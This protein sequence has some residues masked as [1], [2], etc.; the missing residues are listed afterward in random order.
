VKIA[1]YIFV[2]LVAGM[3]GAIT[4]HFSIIP[5]GAREIGLPADVKTLA[6]QE[7]AKRVFPIFSKQLAGSVVDAR[8]TWLTTD[9]GLREN[10]E[11]VAFRL[12]AKGAGW[13]ELCQAD[14]FV[15]GLASPIKPPTDTVAQPDGKFEHHLSYRIIG[16]T[17][18]DK[19]WTDA[20]SGRLDQ[21]CATLGR[22]IEFFTLSDMVDLRTVTDMVPALKARSSANANGSPPVR[23]DGTVEFCRDP[24]QVLRT[25]PLDKFAGAYGLADCGIRESCLELSY[26]PDQPPPYTGHWALRAKGVYSGT[27]PNGWGKMK[28]TD[29]QLV[30]E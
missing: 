23:C 30:R 26:A 6:P 21:R 8:Y 19:E 10:L 12:R 25:L 22:T 4:A 29:V 20:Y 28:L 16:D 27:F 1:G 13:P 11:S 18:P 3:A 9:Q 24:E 14:N 5:L 2:A 7:A 15:I 17:R